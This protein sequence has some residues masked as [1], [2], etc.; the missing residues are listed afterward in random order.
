MAN[1]Q[2]HH[3][4]CTTPECP[5]IPQPDNSLLYHGKCPRC[6]MHPELPLLTQEEY[7]K[8]M[9]AGF[10]RYENAHYSVG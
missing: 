8:E 1:Q 10:D 3:G 6:F 2:R 9:R 5:V 7:D 4:Q